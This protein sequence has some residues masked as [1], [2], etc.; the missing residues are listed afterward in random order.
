MKLNNQIAVIT[1][2]GRGIGKGI[3]E[4]F[5]LEGA[6]VVVATLEEHEGL[7]TVNEIIEKGGSALFV[8]TD[9]SS[10]ESVRAM[11]E[12]VYNT[13]GKIDTLV[14]N[15][16]ITVFKPLVEATVD[17]WNQVIDINLRGVFLCSK[18]TAPYMMKQRKGAIINISSNHAFATIP[19][20]EIYAASKAGI[21][22]MTR[23]MALSLGKHG[24]RV[25]SICPGFTETPHHR[26]WVEEM[27]DPKVIEKEVIGLHAGNRIGTP[28]DVGKLAVYL[29]SDDSEM[30]TGSELLI[31]G[32]LTNHLFH[33][34][35]L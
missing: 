23:S 13:F 21:N 25:N 4:M 34:H 30:M 16:G 1:G 6:T 33:S 22:G 9:V 12:K 26:M 29:A 35:V 7:Q 15:A 10:D 18:Y 8:Q 17:D 19:H 5:T 11:I 27:G 2:A 20:S 31:D 28:H 24:I 3:A 32:G 14:N